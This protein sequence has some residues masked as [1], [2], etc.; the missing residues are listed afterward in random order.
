MGLISPNRERYFVYF[1]KVP[2]SRVVEK[3]WSFIFASGWAM[4]ETDIIERK[5]SII[6]RLK[7]TFNIAQENGA[8]TYG[9]NPEDIERQFARQYTIGWDLE[10]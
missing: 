2:R 4:K 10:K 7:D 5:K 9:N 1:D 8:G 3:L 6:N